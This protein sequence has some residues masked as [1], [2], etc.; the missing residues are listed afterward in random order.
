MSSSELL[1]IYD[2]QVNWLGTKPRDQVHRDG[3]WHR[4]FQCWVIYRDDAGQDF[5]IVQRRAYDKQTFPGQF[6]ISAAGHYAAGETTEDGLRELQEEL[7]LVVDFEDLIPLGRRIAA[8]SYDGLIDHE[9]CEVF[10]L[11]CDQPL[12][13]YEYQRAELAGLVKVPV[14]AA[15]SMCVGE[16]DSIQCE[17]VGADAPIVIV[18]LSDFVPTPDAY[19]YKVL[20]LAKRCL[21]GEKHLIV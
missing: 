16:R 19:F 20:V 7:G 11:I 8:N 4:T 1:D 15:L 9:F 2:E 18:R 13:A 3:N 5:I 14:D 17:A 10:F 21:N 12:A 6:D